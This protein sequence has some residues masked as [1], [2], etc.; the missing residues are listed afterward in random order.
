MPHMVQTSVD[1]PVKE[2]EDEEEG[3]GLVGLILGRL[4]KVLHQ[5]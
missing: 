3:L 5:I 2:E 1:S 4:V